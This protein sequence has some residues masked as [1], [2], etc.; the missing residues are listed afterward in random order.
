MFQGAADGRFVAYSADAGRKL[1]EMP[2]QTGAMAGPISY[3]VNG[4]Q[5]VAVAAGWSGS[6][7]IIGG[8]APTHRATSRI[9]A[10]KLG[11]GTSL[12]PVPPLPPLNPPAQTASPETVARGAALYGQTCRL[13]HGLGAVSGGM[14]PD[15]RYMSA[16]THK[17]FRD[18]VLYGKR[19]KEGMA[20][21]AD[22]YN[23][24]DA[25]AIH[26]YLIDRA[27]AARAGAKP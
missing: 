20:P 10:F 19:A 12:P 21:F 13:C 26:A 17:D 15:L 1:W 18:I 23:V 11:A 9:L 8:M 6:I 4:E 24:E 25:D 16:E 2:I 7:A 5:Y 3:S 22:M 27:I 14:T